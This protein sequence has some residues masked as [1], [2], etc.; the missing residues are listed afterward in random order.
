MLLSMG[1]DPHPGTVTVSSSILSRRIRSA[2]RYTDR[3]GKPDAVTVTMSQTGV[4]TGCFMPGT[5]F[6]DHN[7]T[8]DSLQSN[9]KRPISIRFTKR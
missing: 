1:V 4:E 7:W 9:L 2:G 5:C 6:S 8:P 3:V